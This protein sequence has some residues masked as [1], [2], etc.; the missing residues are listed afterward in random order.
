VIY[1][2]SELAAR[3]GK[4]FRVILPI[5]DPYVAHHGALGSFAQVYLPEGLSAGAVR[6]WL[7]QCPGVTECHE[8][9]TAAKPD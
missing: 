6:D 5:T 8:R 1:L 7:L 4:G 9:E 3:F 2:E